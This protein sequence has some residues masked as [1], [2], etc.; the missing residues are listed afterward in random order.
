[1]TVEIVPVGG[2]GEVGRN[3]TAVK[4]DD[5]VVL[6]DMGLHMSNYIK[7]TEEDVSQFVKINESYLKKAEAIPQDKIIK[8]WRAKVRAIVVTHAHLD[9]IGAVPYLE[10][11]YDAPIICTPFSAAILRTIC[12]DEKI[13]LHNKIIE[14][15]PGKTIQMGSLKIEFIRT[16]HSTPQTIIAALHTKQ[17]AVI[18]ANDYKLDDHPGLGKPPDYKRFKELGKKGVL[19]LMQDCIYASTPGKTPSE[20]VAKEKLNQTLLEVDNKGKGIIVTTFASHVARMKT[21]GEL[22]RRLK[23]KVVFMGRSIAKY[24]YA[25]KDSG[26]TDI[27]KY[28]KIIKYARHAAR[29]LKEIQKE[30]KDKYLIITSGHQGE[31]QAALSKMIDGRYTWNWDGND[32]V[33]FSAH[34]IPTEPNITNRAEMEKK[35]KGLGVKIFTNVHASGHSSGGDM[36]DIITMLKPKHILPTHGEKSMMSAFNIIAKKMGYKL[37]KTLHPLINGQRLVL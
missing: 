6:F 16:T 5:E 24:S 37:D 21:I 23:R 1:M 13:N 34:T 30:G 8:E 10:A 33:I 36:E 4:L 25:A 3:M 7:L 26:V 35:L 27:T 28:G 17:G 9:H 11:K 32:H 31:P 18:Y 29:Q 12:K 2:W 20:L 14:L 19:A 15:M 22:G